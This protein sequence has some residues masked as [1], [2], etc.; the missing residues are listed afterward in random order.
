MNRPDPIAYAERLYDAIC[1]A[2]FSPVSF[3]TFGNAVK[4][5]VS[6]RNLPRI[7]A[8]PFM[9]IVGGMLELEEEAA[10]GEIFDAELSAIASR[11]APSVATDDLQ[12]AEAVGASADSPVETDH[13][14]PATT[15]GAE[16]PGN[17]AAAVDPDASGA[18]DAAPDASPAAT[19]GL[20]SGAGTASAPDRSVNGT[21]RP[22]L[23]G[24]GSTPRKT[25]ATGAGS[26][27]R[28][29]ISRNL[30]EYLTAKPGPDF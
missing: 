26:V 27:R 17:A 7:A 8:E 15:A 18:S 10:D 6:L 1:G 2:N 19:S 29:C 3:L 30:P 20:W 12:A 22:D 24:R 5:G 21:D 23:H 13:H 16:T 11:L 25:G 4:D 28:S 14:S 9:R